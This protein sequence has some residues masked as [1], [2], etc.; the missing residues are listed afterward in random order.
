MGA[1]VEVGTCG[2]MADGVLKLAIPFLVIPIQ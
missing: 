1:G 2:N